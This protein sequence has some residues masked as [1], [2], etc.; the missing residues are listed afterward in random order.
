[1]RPHGGKDSNPHR[2]GWNQ[3]SSPLD[4][5]RSTGRITCAIRSRLPEKSNRLLGRTSWSHEMRA[6]QVRQLFA[7]DCVFPDVAH[8]E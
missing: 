4:D 3:V 5:H 7:A 1:M 2:L 8:S 6:R